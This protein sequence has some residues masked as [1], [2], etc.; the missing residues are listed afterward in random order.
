MDAD[1]AVVPRADGIALVIV[2]NGSGYGRGK[3]REVIVLPDDEARSLIHRL[4]G[5]LKGRAHDMNRL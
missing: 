5:A 4:E 2:T 1:I 3:E